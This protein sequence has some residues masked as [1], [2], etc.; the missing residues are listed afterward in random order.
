MASERF[1]NHGDGT[2]TDTKTG[3]MWAAKD[4]G[5]PIKC[6]TPD[7]IVIITIAI[8]NGDA[9]PERTRKPL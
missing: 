8:P 4:N 1:E 6:Q 7:L 3:L 9:D 5:S 2:F